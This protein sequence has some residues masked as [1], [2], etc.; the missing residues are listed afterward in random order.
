MLFYMLSV[1]LF[2]IV[3]LRA[4]CNFT[5]IADTDEVLTIF[6]FGLAGWC[7]IL[8]TIIYFLNRIMYIG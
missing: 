3:A 6:L 8:P 7:F 1:L 5:R 2:S 4:F